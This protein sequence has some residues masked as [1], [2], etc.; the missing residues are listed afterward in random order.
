MHWTL[1]LNPYKTTRHSEIRISNRSDPIRSD[2]NRT[3]SIRF[4]LFELRPQ[5]NAKGGVAAWPD[6]PKP[7]ATL[8]NLTPADR[9]GSVQVSSEIESDM[10]KQAKRLALQ[11]F[12]LQHLRTFRYRFVFSVQFLLLSVNIVFMNS[13]SD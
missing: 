13:W 2:P 6:V 10:L 3:K 7:G 4:E 11:Q 8:G 5:T 9:H 12:L 1:A